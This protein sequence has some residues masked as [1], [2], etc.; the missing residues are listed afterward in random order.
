[1]KCNAGL[2][3]LLVHVFILLMVSLP[4]L[5]DEKFDEI[6]NAGKYDKA[7]QYADEKIK[8][9]DRDLEIWIK[10]AK[11]IEES[12]GSK[13][14]MLV[15]YKEAQKKNPSD[16]RV[17][18]GFGK[19]Y[20]VSKKYKEALEYF[21]KSYILDNTAQAAEGMAICA[22]HIKDFEK[23]RDAA[24]SAV[25]LDPDLF[26]SRA[27]LAKLFLDDKQYASAATHLEFIVNQK[28][29]ELKYWKQLA[30]CYSQTGNT[31]K[32]AQA[33][34]KIIELDEKNIPSRTRYA[35]YTLTNQDTSAA[36]S[37][38][39]ELAILSEKNP[40]V[41]KNLYEIAFAKGQKKDALLYGKNYLILDSTNATA[42]RDY[43]NLLFEAKRYDE[44]LTSY[45][46][47]LRIDPDIKGFYKNYARILIEKKLE[48]EAISI[49][50]KAIDAGEADKA[51]YVALG[52][53]YRNQKNCAAAI[54]MY[55]KALELDSKDV[56]VLGSLGACQAKTG[57]TDNA[58]ITYEQVVLMD[59]KAGKEYKILG[60]LHLKKGE[61]AD[62]MKSYSTYLTKT[63]DDQNVL[64]K[65]GLYTFG[66]KDYRTTIKHLK[67]VNRESL[68]DADL[69][70]AL[71]QS[72]FH[73][74][75]FQKSAD[76]LAKAR[77]KSPASRDL[78]GLLKTLAD[79]YVKIGQELKAARIYEAY[80]KLSS[81]KDADASYMSAFL[82]EKSDKKAA[83]TMYRQNTKL[84]PNDHR[85][86]LRLGMIYAQD[87]AMLSTSATML[88]QAGKLKKDDPVI[89]HKLA[90]VNQRLSR[91][92]SELS[93]WEKLVA[94][95]PQHLEANRRI[96]A[97]MLDNGKT[98]EA[99]A[100]L[101]IVST[102]APKD[103]EIM[104]LLAEGYIQTNRP[105]KAAELMA[106][107][108][109]Y[110]KDDVKL[111]I[112]LI[113]AYEAAGQK[114][115]VQAERKELAEID[116]K[117]VA[118]DTKNKAALERLA[119]YRYDTESFDEAYDHYKDL[120]VMKPKDTLIV[121]RLYE[122][123]VQKKNKTDA[124]TW[125]RKYLAL[126]PNNAKAY[127]NLGA[128]LY[129]REDKDGALA[130]Y[131]KAQ[132]LDVRLKGLYPKYAE[133]AV[134][135]GLDD[136]AIAALKGAITTGE[137]EE[138]TYIT[139]GKLYHKKKQY[140]T[141]SNYLN[142]ALEKNPK[143][144]DVLTLLAESQSKSGALSDAALTYQQVVM[145]KPDAADEYKALGDLQLKQKK[146]DDAMKSY[147]SYLEKKPA[148]QK[149]ARKVGLYEY[150]KKSYH[151]AIEY[152][153]K[154]SDVSQ[155]NVE[156]LLALGNSYYS[157]QKY[158]DAAR[159]YTQLQAK[160]AKS[161]IAKQFLKKL[162][163]SYEK[164]GDE[165]KAANAYAAYLRLGLK[166]ADAAYL[167]GYLREKTDK[168][169]AVEIYTQNIKSYP[170]DSR[171]FLRLGL[172]Y[173]DNKAM[174]SKSASMLK[175]ASALA[176]DKPDIWQK[177]GQVYGKLNKED[178]ELDAYQK[179]LTFAPQNLQ[180]NRRVG[181]IMMKKGQTKDALAALEIV[182]TMAP[183]DV[184]IMLLL[185]DG[186]M[187]TNRL[188]N[189]VK[190][191]EKAQKIKK[192]DPA[193][194]VQL[195]KLNKKTGKKQ[196]A[197]ASLK[198]AIELT[199][200]NEYR[201]MYAQDLIETKRYED[202]MQIAQEIKKN[203]PVNVDALMLI[204]DIQGLQK[205]YNEAIESYKMVLYIKDDY[206]PALYGRAQMYLMQSKYER[207]T[208]YFQKAL[209]SDAKH[210]KATLGLALVAKAQNKNADYAK[211]VKKASALDPND[212]EILKEL[213]KASN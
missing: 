93:A 130:A 124:S 11:A 173:A 41:F 131:R 188:E 132:K 75:D 179:L 92:D 53:I 195:Y 208:D 12:R 169:R 78:P 112:M 161:D 140:K 16:P 82:R 56:G 1:M 207:A 126:N 5:G 85:N 125:L 134:A 3:H 89:W 58:I 181:T 105:A 23:A 183:K 177:L 191:L 32:L 180:A 94:I 163:K 156:Y 158:A 190:L 69:L 162:G 151:K 121:K 174:L 142:K 6:Y 35:A 87:K 9:A 26:N 15:Y 210:A 143:N 14:K 10:M 2:M 36:F 66:K 176:D 196:K 83:L 46:K 76:A 152:L 52:N 123:S 106:K 203:D 80:T 135:K 33:D 164:T 172:I 144:A 148:D 108:K 98:S 186:Y 61:Q 104:L 4:V 120:A 192:D 145:M 205:K 175:K 193:L 127:R 24:E 22:Y 119:H 138:Q 55:Q 102:Q 31:D 116:K 77:T 49:I 20:A 39:K 81:V 170:Q 45:R 38:Y 206:A 107:A 37:L 97:L 137:A 198:K 213:K 150:E 74:G 100:A 117:T 147:R 30:L 200:K 153:K 34:K 29:R 8:P 18:L 184:D 133:L 62:A 57:D 209:K 40:V 154:V 96:G 160:K 157:L 194:L 64:K 167:N 168:D 113:D 90:K 86:Y 101:E 178:E 128:L 103:V 67:K 114:D 70:L 187:R 84:F 146:V 141:A 99:L 136:E 171:N 122:I 139:L 65:V 25:R 59:D 13:E 43:G 79:S 63:P 54:T 28:P 17:A 212:E 60:D 51:L 50:K 165:L 159:A 166:D 197:E 73:T 68:Q 115:K 48:K 109:T 21:Q 7:L 185:A 129:S 118:K 201:T 44:A 42:N 91:T 182:A 27:I 72:Y 111:R 202:A 19:Y 199:N 149:I 155:Q 110:K 47:A 95:E 71:G 211:L 189:A 204:A 88:A